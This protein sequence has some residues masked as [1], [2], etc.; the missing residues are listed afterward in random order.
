MKIVKLAVLALIL[1]AIVVL[2]IANRETVTLNLLPEGM[3]W[4]APLSLDVPLFLVSLVSILVGMILG[5]FLEWLREYRYRRRA[6]EKSREAERLAREVERLR[7]QT[8]RHED[9]VLALVNS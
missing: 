8:G 5:Y 9:E 6:R 3:H 2:A 1:I 4:L 7:E